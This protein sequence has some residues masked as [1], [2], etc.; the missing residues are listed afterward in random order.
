MEIHGTLQITKPEGHLLVFS[1]RPD[2]RHSA[3]M[4]AYACFLLAGGRPGVV[5]VVIKL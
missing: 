5:V 3:R 2:R 4:H 1:P